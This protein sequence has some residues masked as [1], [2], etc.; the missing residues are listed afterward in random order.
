MLDLS[1]VQSGAD[2]ISGL[3]NKRV[4]VGATASVDSISSRMNERIQNGRNDDVVSAINKLS[5]KLDNAGGSTNIINGIT[6]DDGSNIS[7]AIQSLV[8]AA[9]VER[10][11]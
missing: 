3:L 5:T 11:V 2:A 8:R 10:R 9:R 1:D 6:Y 7:D 4:S